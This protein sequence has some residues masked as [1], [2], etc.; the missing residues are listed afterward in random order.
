MR[1]RCSL[2]LSTHSQCQLFDSEPLH[3]SHTAQ[4]YPQAPC[5][6]GYVNRNVVGPNRV[7]RWRSR[8]TTWCS[9]RGRG[10]RPPTT[11]R[12]SAT[13]PST[14]PAQATHTTHAPRL[15]TAA[16]RW[17]DGAEAPRHP[18]GEGAR[19]VP[20]QPSAPRQERYA[21]RSAQFHSNRGSIRFRAPTRTYVRTLHRH[22]Q[23]TCREPNEMYRC[24]WMS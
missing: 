18:G 11:P 8:C 14:A 7:H 12:C 21:S 2:N 22:V 23:R 24:A 9:P 4:Y 16:P 1:R 19:P 17:R 3:Q 5:I 6:K 20:W 13:R 15:A 10:P